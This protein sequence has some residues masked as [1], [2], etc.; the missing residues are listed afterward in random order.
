MKRD[1]TI[2]L[3]K[4][5]NS[6]QRK[7]LVI[8]GTRQVGKTWLVRDFA[9]GFSSFVEINFEKLPQFSEIFKADLAPLR[10]L[11]ELSAASG[12]KII[13]GETLLFFDEIQQS[14]NALK[15]LRYFYEEV[16]ELHLIAAG[17][18]LGFSIEKV[19]T[20]V[21]RV[22]YLNLYPLSFGEYI[23]AI[24][25]S[26]LREKILCQEIDIPLLKIHHEK[27][28]RLVKS[29][30]LTGGMPAV[31]STYAETQD[32][33]LCRQIQKE[34]I[35]SFSNDFVKYAKESDTPYL[36]KVFSS[37]PIQIGNK[38]MFS[39]VDSSI[40]GFHFSK[41]LDLLETAG[42]IY[43]V[44]QSKATG[45]PLQ[46]QI[47][48]NRFKVIF[49]DIGLLQHLM[50]IDLQEW[51][52]SPEIDDVYKGAIAEQ[53]VGQELA[54]LTTAGKYQNLI[55]WH[56][57]KRNSSAEI[58]YLLELYGDIIPVEVK[59]NVRGGMKSMAL[60]LKE[61][62]RSLGFKI[63]KYPFSFNNQIRTIPFYAIE[64]LFSVE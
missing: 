17:S 39:R 29:Y 10:I 3:Q 21:G 5:R 23:D 19:T 44:Y 50:N 37:I 38:F 6:H 9:G 15:T 53:F 2:E 1:K 35:L 22:S 57:E 56:R 52:T 7:P 8:Q 59:S 31:V 40:R 41:A 42:I 48:S 62:K 47:N 16:P 58:D 55:Y 34:L 33:L 45:L 26:Q 12:Q 25:E 13:P 43:K 11:S 28:L 30:M 49:F 46:S 20:G 64:K 24:G 61:K 63:S 14:S 60:F 18:L 4:W 36:N 54:S 51:M 32:F 27:L